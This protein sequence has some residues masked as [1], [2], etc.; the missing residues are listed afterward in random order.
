[1]GSRDG[2]E[3]AGQHTDPVAARG[4]G[5]N[6]RRRSSTEAESCPSERITE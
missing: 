6:D 3:S 5:Q 4:S 2:I 1:V